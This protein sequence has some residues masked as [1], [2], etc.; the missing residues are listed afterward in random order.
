MMT[1]STE[2]KLLVKLQEFEKSGL[3]LQNCFSL[4]SLVVHCE[5]NSKYL[6]HVIKKYRGKDFNNYINELRINYILEKLGKYPQ[7]RN[8]KMA[9]LAAE[10]G[11][12]SPNKFAMVF[13]KHT[14]I[15][16]SLFVKHL[17]DKHAESLM[18]QEVCNDSL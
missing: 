16:P 6:S 14:S 1:N 15:S 4:S 5:T 9:T 2:Q 13:K 11:F 17:A 18:R 3:Y 7:Y 10:A 8:Y 12:S